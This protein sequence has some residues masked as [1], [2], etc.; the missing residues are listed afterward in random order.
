MPAIPVTV[1]DNNRSRPS[2]DLEH[3]MAEVIARHRAEHREARE[4]SKL[5]YEAVWLAAMKD[6][7]LRAAAAGREDP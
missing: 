4:R 3:R 5:M 2:A 7:M 1:P 6:L